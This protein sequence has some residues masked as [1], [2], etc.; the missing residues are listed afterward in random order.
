[1]SLSGEEQPIGWT[2]LDLLFCAVVSLVISIGQGVLTRWQKSGISKARLD[3]TG[4]WGLPE[5][6][7]PDVYT[8]LERFWND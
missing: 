5:T 7:G 3:G 4:L 8:R 6:I 1:M 2:Q